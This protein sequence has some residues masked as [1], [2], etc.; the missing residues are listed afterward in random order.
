[1]RT[2]SSAGPCLTLSSLQDA[3]IVQEQDQASQPKNVLDMP[4]P[5]FHQ[6]TQHIKPHVRKARYP[7]GLST[8]PS[9]AT[10]DTDRF[11][12]LLMMP[13]DNATDSFHLFSPPYPLPFKMAPCPRELKIML[14]NLNMAISPDCNANEALSA[15]GC[16]PQHAGC[17]TSVINS[18]VSPFH[19]CPASL[20]GLQ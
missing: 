10:I 7:S 15:H 8:K 19:R 3:P 4:E 1:M 18:G 20:G 16:L 5:R 2:S 9:A 11:L 6:A 17:L 12:A 14:P 13:N